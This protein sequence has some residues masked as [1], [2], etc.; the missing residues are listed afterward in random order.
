MT[1]PRR[2]LLLLLT[3]AF[4]SMTAKAADNVQ[5]NLVT[6]EVE[7][8]LAILETASAG[9]TP[10]EKQWQALWQSAGYRR[11][12]ER[13]TAMGRQEGFSDKLAAWL[14]APANTGRAA[15]FRKLV[16]FWRGFDA[17][18]AG[19][20]AHAYLPQGFVLRATLY[21]VIKHT[22][23][24]FVFDVQNDPAIF[25]TI[26][27]EDSVESIAATMTHELHHI[28]LGQCPALADY[29]KLNPRQ[30]RAVDW[31]SVFGEGLAVLATAGGPMRHP[32]FYST[33]EEYL[34][35]ERDVANFKRDIPRVEA[36]FKSILDGSLPEERQRAELFTFIATEDIPQG[37]AYTAGWKMA[38]LVERRFGHAA[39]VSVMCDPRE[40]LKLYNRAASETVASSAEN[41]PLWS[42]DFIA[43]LYAGSHE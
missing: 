6:D 26:N 21:P 31:L 24:T 34:V 4:L 19:E 2:W 27:P 41:L 29:D 40:L 14:Q 22:Q 38:A 28:G 36:F 37:A 10:S 23:N 18:T 5:I 7:A 35:W 9:H 17:A 39:L 30:Q 12:L 1:N 33:P 15:E 32:H 43:S 11:L 16:E 25:M 13:E 20:R 42:E 8:A 3:S